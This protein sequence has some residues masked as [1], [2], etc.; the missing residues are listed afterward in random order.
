M[1]PK[2]LKSLIKKTQAAL[3]WPVSVVYK[4]DSLE[5]RSDHHD[6]GHTITWPTDLKAAGE[7]RDI[8]YLHELAH[9]TLCETVH[10]LFSTIC[11]E[12]VNEHTLDVVTPCF[13]ATSDW[14]A[15]AWLM[16][17]APDYEGP[18]IDDHLVIVLKSL[19]DKQSGSMEFLYGASLIIAQGIYYRNARLP[20]GGTLKQAVDAFLSVPPEKPTIQKYAKLVNLLLVPLQLRAKLTVD[21]SAWLISE[22]GEPPHGR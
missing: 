10:P 14:F 15:D 6:R 13:R 22:I 2:K 18:D 1:K 7:V 3:Q 9:A 21:Q 8:E 12:G 5:I 16:K 19:Q 4:G 11:F 17:V 20:L